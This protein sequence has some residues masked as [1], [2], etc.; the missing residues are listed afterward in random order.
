MSRSKET[1]RSKRT[2]TS[3]KSKKAPKAPGAATGV[4]HAQRRWRPGTVALREIRQFS[5]PRTFFCRRRPSSAW[6][7]RC[8]VRRR[9]ACASR[10]ARF[11]RR[12]RRRSPYVVSLLADTNRACIHSGRVTIQ[13]KDIHLALC[14]RGER[15]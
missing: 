7:V 5:A 9:R 14:L 1:A 3:K 15:A 13:P 2:I 12:R 6:C 10:A 4:K 11:L 8:R